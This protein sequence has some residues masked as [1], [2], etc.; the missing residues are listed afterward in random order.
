M[1]LWQRLC[2]GAKTPES[3]DYGPVAA[4]PR[5]EMDLSGVPYSIDQRPMPQGDDPETLLSREV[6]D[7]LRKSLQLPRDVHTGSIYAEYRFGRSGIFVELGICDDRSGALNALSTAKRETD[8]EFPDDPQVF[9][10]QED[11]SFLR[12]VNRLGA[13]MAWT[14]GRYYFSAHAK[15]GAA[16]L[17]TFMRAFPY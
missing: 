8:A 10:D 5:A 1:S 17:E 11:P 12:T 4:T 9:F 3:T 14:R 15:R 6:G 16:D 7:Y 13:F 2:G